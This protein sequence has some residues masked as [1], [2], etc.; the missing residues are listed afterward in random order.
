MP[1]GKGSSVVQADGLYRLIIKDEAPA[2]VV[3]ETPE[4]VLVSTIIAMEVPLVD[5]VDPAFYEAV[6]D[7]DPVSVDAVAGTIVA[8]QEERGARG[9]EADGRRARTVS[10]SR[11]GRRTIARRGAGGP[12]RLHAASSRSC[13]RSTTSRRRCGRGSTPPSARRRCASSP[14]A[15]P[16]SLVLVE[17]ARAH[18]CRPH[19]AGPVRLAQRSRRRATTTSRSSRRPGTHRIMTDAEVRAK[20][21]D[22]AYGRVAHLAA[23][24]HRWRSPW[25]ISEPVTPAT[26]EIPV[27]VNRKVL[28]ADLLIGLGNIL[29]A[30]RRRL[31]RRRQDPAAGRLRVRHDRGDARRRDPAARDPAG[32]GGQ[33]RARGH[34]GGGAHRRPGLHHQR[35]ARPPRPHPRRSS[36]ATSSRLTARAS[37]SRAAP[38]A[39]PSPSPPTSSSSARTRPTSTGGRRRRASSRPTSPSRR[40]ASS[41]SRRR[42]PRA[43][44]TTTPCCATGCKLSFAEGCARGRGRR[45]G[46]RVGRPDRRRPGRGQ[47]QDP[48]EGDDPAWSATASPTTTSSCSAIERLPDLQAAVDRALELSPGGTIGMLPVRRRLPAAG[49]GGAVSRTT[50][51]AAPRRRPAVPAGLPLAGGH[52]LSARLRNR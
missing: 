40:A 31:L 17:D 45:P 52:R 22:E 37:R 50:A 13:R 43:S 38:G 11:T 23:R 20:V 48:R 30:L 7:G 42:A 49:R 14:R 47:R 10:S 16:R 26:I 25:S 12:H 29:P 15:Q 19:P 5:E 51:A 18:P 1:T 35:G 24:L 9:R 21:G 46:R 32:R 28:D 41:C 4:P 3:I 6:E 27:Q 2:A 36:P 8:A 39:C 44:S 33:P 34:G